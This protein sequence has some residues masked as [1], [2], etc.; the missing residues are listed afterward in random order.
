MNTGLHALAATRPN[1]LT[2]HAAVLNTI[3]RH[4]ALTL[5][6]LATTLNLREDALRPFVTD[7]HAAGYLTS[8]DP[9]GH[10]NPR[11]VA[12]PA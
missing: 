4:D 8:P 11:Y 12:T 7:L 1:G 9:T 10:P 3:R 6:A 5:H 2:S